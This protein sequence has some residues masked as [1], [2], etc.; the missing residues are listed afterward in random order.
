MLR[1]ES[2]Y[3]L[4][5]ALLIGLLEPRLTRSQL[6]QLKSVLCSLRLKATVCIKG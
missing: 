3:C 5:K 4:L 6:M 1:V 2:R